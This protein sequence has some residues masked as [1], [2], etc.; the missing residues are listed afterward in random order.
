M[1][2]LL[3]SYSGILVCCCCF[4]VVVIVLVVVQYLNIQ[5][6]I[7]DTVEKLSTVNFKDE[8]SDDAN[9]VNV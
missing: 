3:T 1:L 5:G 2:L 4:V 6:L 8:D 7:L 9:Y